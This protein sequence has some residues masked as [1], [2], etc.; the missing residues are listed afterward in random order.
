MLHT[1]RELDGSSSPPRSLSY[2]PYYLR[3]VSLL[4][5]ISAT[6]V[7]AGCESPNLNNPHQELDSTSSSVAPAAPASDTVWDLTLAFPGA[8]TYSG[9][10]GIPQATQI[11][12][13]LSLVGVTGSAICLDGAAA[14]SD[15]TL[16]PQLISG[17]VLYDSAGKKVTGTLPL[18]ANVN[19]ANG[20][21]VLTIPQGFYDGTKTASA[22]DTNLVAANIKAGTAIFGVTGTATLAY[23]ACSDN[24]LNASQCSTAA[25]R[26]VASA[27]G[28]DVTG[29]NGSLSVTI[30]QGY[31]SGTQTATASDTN[32]VAG[33]IIGGVAIFGVTGS[34]P[35]NGT[36]AFPPVLPVSV[37]SYLIQ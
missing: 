14:T 37:L 31:Y 30:P 5:A 32:L 9:V 29:A 36:W 2:T 23:G 27:A 17:T 3:K 15:T 25:S 4:L 20:T 34:I 22:S 18:G 21:N 24:A 12:T 11:C 6:L 16:P 26:Y 35:N 28:S 13:G 10:N 7:F 19:G 8:G 1:Q 33:N